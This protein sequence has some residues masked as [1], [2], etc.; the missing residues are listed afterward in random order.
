MD[1]F[2][3]KWKG[4]IIPVFNHSDYDVCEHV[5]EACYNGGI[6]V[7]EFTNRGENAYDIFVRLQQYNPYSDLSLGVGSVVYKQDAVR[8][9]DAGAR[10]IVG[11]CLSLPVLEVCQERKIPYIPGC[12][13]ITEIFNAQ[14]LGCE[15]TKL[16]PGDVYG[17][18]MVK[19]LMAPMPWSKVMVTGGVK[20]EKDN[21]DTWFQ[22]GAW[23]VGMGSQLFTKQLLESHDYETLT[24]SLQ[25]LI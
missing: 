24:R 18:A 9:I 21:L 16:F 23:C 1:A 25:Q 11:P 6:R 12:G 3:D 19:D 13:T 17:P 15:L 8:F 5:L 10:F 7:F 20:P 14:Q 4:Q 2:Y 22:A